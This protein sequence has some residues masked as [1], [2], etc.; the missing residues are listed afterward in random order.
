MLILTA[1]AQLN[2][3][4]DVGDFAACFAAKV[5]TLQAKFPDKMDTVFIYAAMA[6][7]S[8][9]ERYL[10]SNVISGCCKND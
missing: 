5:P 10:N 3:E 9:G 4:D 7:Y 6:S 2:G 1:N 8:I